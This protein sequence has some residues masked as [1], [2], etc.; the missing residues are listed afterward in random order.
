MRSCIVLL[1][2]LFCQASI[3]SE[4]VETRYCFAQPLRDSDGKIK[5]RK[6]VL[7]AFKQ[8]HPCPAN[9]QT[10]GPCPGWYMDHVIPLAC[11]GCDSVNNLQWLPEAQW[12]AKSK[13]ERKI[14]CKGE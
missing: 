14:Y 2:V 7:N 8:Y 12:K 1:L 13:F 3:A 10:S 9:G 11:G 6:A 5:R 4:V